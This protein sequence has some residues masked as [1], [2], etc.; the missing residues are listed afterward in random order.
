MVKNCSPFNCK[1]DKE[2][3]PENVHVVFCPH[4]WHSFEPFMCLDHVKVNRTYYIPACQITAITTQTAPCIPLRHCNMVVT[5]VL[6][7]KMV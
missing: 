4:K 6:L 3:Y 7:G 5:T 1:L 2:V